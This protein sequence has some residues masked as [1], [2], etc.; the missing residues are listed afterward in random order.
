MLF[1]LTILLEE[2]FIANENEF[3]KKGKH[4]A[5]DGMEVKCYAKY[6]FKPTI[7]TMN[8]LKM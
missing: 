2:N 6:T 5:K 1:P 3:E 7:Q 4:M 8:A